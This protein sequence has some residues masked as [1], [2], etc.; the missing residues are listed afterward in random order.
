MRGRSRPSFE[1]PAYLRAGAIARLLGVHERSVRRW[2][3][4]GLLPS[5]CI[6]GARLVARVD[7]ERLLEGRLELPEE[8]DG[9]AIE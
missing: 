7:L 5:R 8:S 6:G 1:V 2:L 3:R 4:D 9:G